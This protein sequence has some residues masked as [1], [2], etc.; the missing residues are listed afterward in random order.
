[1]RARHALRRASDEVAR[2]QDVVHTKPLRHPVA[3]CGDVELRGS[4]ARG[5]DA[6]GY[7]LCQLAQRLVSRVRVRVGIDYADDGLVQLLLSITA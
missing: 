6:L 2:R 4:P 7:M 5:P 1:M 3:G